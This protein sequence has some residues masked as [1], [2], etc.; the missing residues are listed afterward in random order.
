MTT[1]TH[2]KSGEERRESHHIVRSRKAV[3]T[4]TAPAAML[5][6]VSHFQIAWPP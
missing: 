6:A 5:G 3:P 2:F 1:G 4:K